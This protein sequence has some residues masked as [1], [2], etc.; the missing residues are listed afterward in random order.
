MHTCR[1]R[2][3]IEEVPTDGH[4]PMKFLCDDGNLYYCKYRI[5]ANAIELDFLAYEVV[6]YTL[7]RAL[8]LPTPDVAL[9]E[10]QVGS[11]RPDQLNANRRFIKPGII[12]FGSRALPHADLVRQTE[13]VCSTRAFKRL[14][15]PTDLIRLAV[16]DLWADNTDRGRAFEGGYNYNL[17]CVPYEG[18]TQFV[19]FDNAFTFGGENGLRIFNPEWPLLPQNRLFNSPYYKAVVKHITPSRR[20]TVANDCLSLCYERGKQAIHT[21][22]ASLPPTWG[23]PPSLRTRMVDFLLNDQRRIAIQTLLNQSIPF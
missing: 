1:T 19:A 21:A 20:F 18:K 12:C 13:A 23:T 14:L 7:L 15:N 10:V 22:F 17:L 6:S 3:L 11:Y 9:V 16:F 4:S 2:T 5:R 8:N